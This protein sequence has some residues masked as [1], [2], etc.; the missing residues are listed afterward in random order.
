[1]FKEIGKNILFSQWE[2]KIYTLIW[3]Y[4]NIYKKY[5]DVPNTFKGILL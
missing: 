4:I 2:L 5:N 3:K 1:M